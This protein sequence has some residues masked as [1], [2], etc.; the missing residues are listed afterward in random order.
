MNDDGNTEYVTGDI[1]KSGADII[2]HQTNCTTRGAAKGIAKDIFQAYPYANTYTD[3]TWND[4]RTPGK[5]I[6]IA[7]PREPSV[8]LERSSTDTRLPK[9]TIVSCCNQTERLAER[10]QPTTSRRGSADL[11]AS[12]PEGAQSKCGNSML[13]KLRYC[14]KYISKALVEASAGRDENVEGHM[15]KVLV[16]AQ[17]VVG[18]E[19][20]KQGG[21]QLTSLDE[22]IRL[23]D[24]WPAID[25][26]DLTPQSNAGSA[27]MAN[28]VEERLFEIEKRLWPTAG[29]VHSLSAKFKTLD[30][31]QDTMQ[32]NARTLRHDMHS[33]VTRMHAMEEEMQKLTRK[34][35]QLQS[36]LQY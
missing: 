10:E 34:V 35:A 33:L 36:T 2:V 28:P 25:T 9:A 24:T 29:I 17:D 20:G 23:V 31:L 3:P 11:S 1:I 22:A 26:P 13:D 14:K 8:G 5:T 15:I 27:P 6:I 30:G 4:R 19:G 16:T 21:V 12:E 7:P 32:G 18:G